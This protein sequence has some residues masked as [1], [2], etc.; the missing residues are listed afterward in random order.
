MGIVCAKVVVEAA[1]PV[2]PKDRAICQLSS[3]HA[4]QRG[5][6]ELVTLGPLQ[7]IP[8]QPYQ[9]S[10]TAHPAHVPGA[11]CLFSGRSGNRARYLSNFVTKRCKDFQSHSTL[12]KSPTVKMASECSIFANL[13]AES[14]LISRWVRRKHDLKPGLAASSVVSGPYSGHVET[15]RCLQTLCMAN[16]K[17]L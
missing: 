6:Q 5:F 3:P 8:H 9:A 13:T 1:T 10:A 2:R 11:A 12:R 4:H 16:P 17:V 7:T 14:V 15:G